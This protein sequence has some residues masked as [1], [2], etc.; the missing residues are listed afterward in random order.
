M[1]ERKARKGGGEERQK[2][3]KGE[4]KHWFSPVE[5][6]CTSVRILELPVSQTAL[7]PLVGSSGPRFHISV[8]SHS[9]SLPGSGPEQRPPPHWHCYPA[10][11]EGHQLP[12]RVTFWLSLVWNIFSD[13]AGRKRHHKSWDF[14]YLARIKMKGNRKQASCGPS[15]TFRFLT[16]RN[17]MPRS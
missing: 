15:T 6:C 4:R 11:G 14:F 10:A 17:L 3:G 8:S 2:D 16:E 5:R 9:W 1:E 7:W 13:Q 12:R